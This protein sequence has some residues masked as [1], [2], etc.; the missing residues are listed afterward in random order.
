[1]QNQGVSIDK[2][3][4]AAFD[5]DN[6]L[7]YSREALVYSINQILPLY[8]LPEWETVKQ[9][10]NRN[11]SFRDN[12]PRIF[13]S[14]ADEAYEK[15][16]VVYKNNAERFLKK[17]DKAQDVLELL[18]Q[19]GVKIVIVSNK[20]RMLFDFELP[21]LYDI[22][23]FD[24]VVCGHEAQKDKPYPEQLEFA[25]K[26]FVQKINA[27]KVWMIGDSPM[28]SMCALSA[29]AKAI[30]IGKPI[31]G[32]DDDDKNSD[33]LFIDDFKMFWQMLKEQDK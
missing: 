18:K 8:N 11:L 30:R 20:D 25:V 14:K 15:Y 10:R 7:A 24:K 12:F 13:G 31:W 4:V 32:A 6:T 3:Q 1:M 26:N 9:L 23:L 29:G 21:F 22:A 33:I 2:L 17:P 19:R 16:R 5:W 28:D 27:D